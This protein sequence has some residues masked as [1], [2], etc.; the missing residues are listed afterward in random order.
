MSDRPRVPK[1]EVAMASDAMSALKPDWREAKARMTDWWAGRKTDRVPAR[2]TAPRDGAPPRKVIGTHEEQY[3]SPAVV[4][5]NLDNELERGFFGGEAFPC[6]FV[7][8]GAVPM[9]MFL[10]CQPEFRPETVWQGRLPFGWDQWD[11]VNFDP[12]NRWWR[13]VCDLHRASCRRSS[14]TCARPLTCL[15]PLPCARPRTCASTSRESRTGPG[16]ATSASAWMR[17]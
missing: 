1:D 17:P 9:G 2:V 7:Y 8:I 4:F 12:A 14:P 15:K 5:A 6:H 11:R 13:Y 10:G 16:P 3:V